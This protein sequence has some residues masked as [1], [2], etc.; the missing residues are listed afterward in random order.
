MQKLPV[1]RRLTLSFHA[2]ELYEQHVTHGDRLLPVRRLIELYKL[3]VSNLAGSP[4][5]L[6]SA[7]LPTPTLL[8][9]L[10]ATFTSMR[11]LKKA[12][13][14]LIDPD[15]D[16]TTGIVLSLRLDDAKGIHEILKSYNSHPVREV[17]LRRGVDFGLSRT[18]QRI[19]AVA[20]IFGL[21]NETSCSRCQASK[22]PF[23][24]C[25]SLKGFLSG[26][27]TNCY[28]DRTGDRP[29]KCSNSTDGNYIMQCIG[30]V[31]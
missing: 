2:S 20:H 22:G 30:V 11:A 4:P 7:V 14:T 9:Y 19:A 31:G 15:P 29:C 5:A 3:F 26:G 12:L 8:T 13:Q 27:C 6:L 23:A 17:L 18:S 25:I 28:Y 1:L 16:N 21:Q 24:D 10:M